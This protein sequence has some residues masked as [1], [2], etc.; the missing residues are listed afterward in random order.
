MYLNGAESGDVR[1]GVR[2]APTAQ[3]DATEAPFLRARS[4]YAPHAMQPRLTFEDGK[5]AT[6]AVS[7]SSDRTLVSFANEMFIP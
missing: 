5:P 3:G 7:I 1:I 4:R 2:I 6:S